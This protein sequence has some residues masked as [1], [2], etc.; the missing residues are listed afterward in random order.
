MT[1]ITQI[2]GGL[3]NQLFQYATG[4]ALALKFGEV[5]VLDDRWYG[6]QQEG[7]TPRSFLLSRLR[8]AGEIRT[9]RDSIRAPKRWRRIAQTIWPC[10]PFVFKERR[11]YVFEKSLDR[12]RPYAS[13]DLYLMGYWQSFRYF[14][15]IRPELLIE[16]TP[17]DSLASHYERYCDQILHTR[18]AT[19]V[20]IRRGDYVNLP[21]AAKIHGALDLSYYQAAMK[22][23]VQ[24]KPNAQFFVFSDDIPWAKAYLPFQERITFIENLPQEDAVVQELALMRSCQHH[25]I[26]NSSLSWWGAWL[27][28]NPSQRVLCPT[29]WLGDPSLPLDDLLPAQWQ[30]I[31]AL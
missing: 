16:F 12:M 8:I 19:M 20:H 1:I 25:I 23:L 5:L 15:S 3:G 31:A 13:Q 2:Q 10:S 22:Q 6:P 29:R 11:G 14:E 4:R 24:E 27:G 21:S 18:D 9:C 7:V 17:M 28:N 30:R 26:A